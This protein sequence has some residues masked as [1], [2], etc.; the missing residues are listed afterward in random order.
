MPHRIRISGSFGPRAFGVLEKGRHANDG[1]EY[2]SNPCQRRRAIELNG[3][4]ISFGSRIMRIIDLLRRG[5]RH[6][7]KSQHRRYRDGRN[8]FS[9]LHALNHNGWAFQSASQGGF[10]GRHATT[11]SR[12]AWPASGNPRPV[13]R[14]FPTWRICGACGCDIR[15]DRSPSA[16][17]SGRDA[18]TSLARGA[19]ADQ[20]NR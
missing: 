8:S 15:P 9:P 13:A 11:S 12:S 16:S 6:A 5:M 14:P 18:D 1:N 20:S 19:S 2:E 17:T 4:L 7:R 3:I 10:P